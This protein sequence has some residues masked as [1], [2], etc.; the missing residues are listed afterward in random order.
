MGCKDRAHCGVKCGKAEKCNHHPEWK[1]G[2]SAA[3]PVTQTCF[4]HPCQE[5]Q[6]TSSSEIPGHVTETHALPKFCQKVHTPSFQILAEWKH[7][8]QMILWRIIWSL[9]FLW[10]HYVLN[11]SSATDAVGRN[12]AY[13][14][15]RGIFTEANR[16]QCVGCWKVRVV[17]VW[18]GKKVSHVSTTASTKSWWVSTALSGSY[19]LG[20]WGSGTELIVFLSEE[21]GWLCRL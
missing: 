10:L 21:C 9:G 7:R 18:E 13:V 15:H 2:S 5:T 16:L 12:L 4:L 6:D 19:C 20:I 1:Y 11:N 8:N 3:P 17:H 14:P